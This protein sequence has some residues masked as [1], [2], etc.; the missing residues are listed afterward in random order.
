M[1]VSLRG[2]G[3]F[4]P[5]LRGLQ[6]L[7]AAGYNDTGGGITP[8]NWASMCCDPWFGGLFYS[9]DDA[10]ACAAGVTGTPC[11]CDTF[12]QANPA[13]FGTG[14]S[15]CSAAA[16]SLVTIPPPVGTVA[17]VPVPSG[18]LSTAPGVTTVYVPTLTCPAS[19]S[20]CPCNGQPVVDD[21]SQQALETCQ[22]LQ[23][24]TAQTQNVN[25]QLT[26]NQAAQCTNEKVVCMQ[27]HFY[28]A[29][30][31]DCSTCVLDFSNANTWLVMAAA[32]LL[33]IGLVKGL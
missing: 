17:T 24:S 3:T 19:V 9:Y 16:L 2:V 10:G 5:A 11:D 32:V 22:A 6:G 28:T 20:P 30:S 18:S 27:N 29:V 23:Q 8:E 25:T 7:G 4:V 26:A 14:N 33:G 31:T 1:E 15:P 21:T 13:L 12:Q